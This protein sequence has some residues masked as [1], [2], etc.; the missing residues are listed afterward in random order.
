M[1]GSHRSFVSYIDKSRKYYSA[2]GYDQPYRWA[3]HHDAPFT[4]LTKPLETAR[5]ALVTTANLPDREELA[6]YAA[7]SEPTPQA[8]RTE[9]LS[10]HKSATTTD[11]LGSFLPLEHLRSLVDA[12]VIGSASPNFVGIS[13]I[14][15]Q[16]RTM[17]WADEVLTMLRADDVDLAVLIPI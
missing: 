10:W 5:V 13:T 9:H 8:M 1:T 14:Y 16:R 17:T 6:P 7:P 15:S 3:T 11:D 4:P 12:G 2:Q